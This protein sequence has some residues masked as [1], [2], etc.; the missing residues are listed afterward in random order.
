MLYSAWGQSGPEWP[1]ITELGAVDAWF[2]RIFFR[3]MHQAAIGQRCGID[4]S[5]VRP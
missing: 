2:L 3:G 4:S 5:Q 1:K